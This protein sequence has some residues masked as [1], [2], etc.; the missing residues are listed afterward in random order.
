MGKIFFVA[1]I[2]LIGIAVFQFGPI[3][4]DLHACHDTYTRDNDDVGFRSRS[5]NYES[6]YVCSQT[7]EIVGALDRC[8][9]AAYASR[10]IGGDIETFID[11]I[12]VMT[13][14]GTKDITVIKKQHDADCESYQT[15]QFDPQ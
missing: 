14:P 11:Q 9:Q 12:F 4:S 6:N 10:G 7:Y 2:I 1:V 15:Y 3:I 13:R 5:Q 8:I